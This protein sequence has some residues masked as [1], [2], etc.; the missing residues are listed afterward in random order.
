MID[1]VLRN[2]LK[3]P[4]I[5]NAGVHAHEAAVEK[6]LIS[7]GFKKSTK[8]SLNLDAEQ[9]KTCTITK[10]IV[11]HTYVWQPCGSQSFPDFIVSDA[12]GNVHYIECKSSKADKITWNSGY[13]KNKAIYIHSSG[14][15]NKQSIVVGEDL[16]DSDDAK[17][18]FECFE[19]MKKIEK[20]YKTKLKNS[21]L[22][23]YCREMYND[24]GKIAGHPDR[25]QRI[26][27]VFD[28]LAGVRDGK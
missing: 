18:L 11:P 27:R 23:P 19:K 9:I 6:E 8:E 28:F 20:Q 3:L 4:H 1:K 16:W 2:I 14:K 22:S 17:L 21:N 10:K 15:Y 25:G 26:K 12:N 24:N 7:F 13:P 5:S